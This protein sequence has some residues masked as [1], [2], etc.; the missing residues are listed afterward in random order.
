MKEQLQHIHAKNKKFNAVGMAGE[1]FGFHSD[2]HY[3]ML[4]V[5]PSWKPEK[6]L[7]ETDCEVTVTAEHSYISGYEVTMGDE[8]IA[9]MQ[10]ASGACNLIDHLLVCLDL[11]F[12]KLVF[13][14]AVGA[15]KPGFQVGDVCTPV[16]CIAGTM[17]DAY[18]LDDFRDWQPF[19]EVTPNDPGFVEE[20]IA[21]ADF[22]VK[23]AG[24]YCTDSISCE[25]YHL[26]FIK[27]FD[28]D[29]IEMET[30]SFYRLADLMEKKA[31]ALLVVSDNSAN[32]E[33]LLGMTEEQRA[34]YHQGRNI[35]IPRLLEKIAQMD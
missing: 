29:L 31:V 8:R 35:L 21:L 28:A 24:V 18:L 23:K 27:G 33:P 5:A 7:N 22:P 26:D 3:D 17:A 25:Y 32:G 14:G 13:L 19:R 16:R 4:V 1:Y 30:S 34:R 9:W 15:L 10:C 12:D 6:I 11:D 2:V 20:V